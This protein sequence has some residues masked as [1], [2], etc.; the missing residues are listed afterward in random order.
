MLSGRDG[1]ILVLRAGSVKARV[2]KLTLR[3]VLLLACGALSFAEDAPAESEHE[4]ERAGDEDA[5]ERALVGVGRPHEG[6][7]ESDRPRDGSDDERGSKDAPEDSH[8]RWGMPPNPSITSGSTWNFSSTTV[9][10]LIDASVSSD[11]ISLAPRAYRRAI[12][13][14]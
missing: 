6:A 3:R 12:S 9:K 10:I 1:T 14:T 13:R 2:Y 8:R 7:E 11:T 5:E 4:A